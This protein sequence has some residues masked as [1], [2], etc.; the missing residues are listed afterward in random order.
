MPAPQT[1]SLPSETL[2]VSVRGTQSAGPVSAPAPAPRAAIVSS[3]SPA[4]PV[5][6]ETTCQDTPVETQV[7]RFK[8]EYPAT[9]VVELGTAAL[10]VDLGKR[11]QLTAWDSDSSCRVDVIGPKDV[12]AVAIARTLLGTMRS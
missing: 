5:W 2:T 7:T 8:E 6:I 11:Q 4:G 3:T 10:L 1:G 12:D 9:T